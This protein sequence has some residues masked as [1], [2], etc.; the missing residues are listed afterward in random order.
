MKRICLT[1]FAF[2]LI[3]MA[4]FSA[5]CGKPGNGPDGEGGNTGKKKLKIVTTLYA[6][7]DFAVN[8]AGDGADVNMLLSPGEESHSYDP[9]PQDIIS[10][11]NCDLF[12]YN[13]GENEDWVDSVLASVG[14]NVRVLRMMDVV[15]RVYTEE[16][17]EGMQS[18]ESGAGGDDTEGAVGDG[19]E[20][21]HAD[22]E[23]TD[24]SE[25]GEYD[26]HV[27]AS[28][29]N[30]IA[31]VKAVNHELAELDPENET[32]YGERTEAYVKEL[33]DV[34]D[35]IARLVSGSKRKLLVFGD[36]F[37][38]RYFTEEFGLDYCAAFPGCS[39]D[40][41]ADA[42]TI[43]FLIDKVKEE[44]VPV[45]FKNEMSSGTIAGAIADE[46]GADVLTLYACHNISKEDYD[47]GVGYVD[48][49]RRNIEALKEA[50]N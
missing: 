26:E 33:S 23:R 18:G 12:I 39:A 19:G 25:D 3:C 16:L 38:M 35:E 44:N 50:L 29:D 32:L 31:I 9:T 36:R 34:R 2:L 6:P 48:L 27:W 14:G 22:E 13:G 37:P 28:I 15:D 21:G 1:V 40:T 41:D 20:H 47:A 4:M 24:V 30:A 42:A 10:I 7:Y 11:E 17:V 43:K 49:M 46:T 5:S 8:I 45:V